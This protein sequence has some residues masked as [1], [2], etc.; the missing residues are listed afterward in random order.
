MPILISQWALIANKKEL[1]LEIHHKY[2]TYNKNFEDEDRIWIMDSIMKMIRSNNFGEQMMR[3][4]KIV[5]ELLAVNT[6]LILSH[7]HL[8]VLIQVR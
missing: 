2:N 8:I 4:H 3:I 7:D 1:L 5:F 6:E